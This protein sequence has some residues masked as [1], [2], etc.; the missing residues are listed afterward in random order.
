[1]INYIFNNDFINDI[2][3]SIINFI[4]RANINVNKITFNLSL[5]TGFIISNDNELY[6]NIE[7]PTIIN[8]KI[9]P[10][11][12]KLGGGYFDKIDNDFYIKPEYED[13]FIFG[14]TKLL[15]RGASLRVEYAGTVPVS[16]SGNG[17]IGNE[18]NAFDNAFNSLIT[19]DINNYSSPDFEDPYSFNKG[20]MR[21]ILAIVGYKPAITSYFNHDKGL[22]IALYSLS[23][24]S[25][26]FL[27]IYDRMNL[28][29]YLINTKK[30]KL[31]IKNEL[32]EKTIDDLLELKKEDLL[33]LIINKLYIPYINSVP[34]DKRK[35]VRDEIL[36]GFL[37]A[38][39]A[40]LKINDLN[41]ENYYY[42]SLVNN[43][44]SINNKITEQAWTYFR[45]EVDE[46]YT[47]KLNDIHIE[48]TISNTK[49]GIKEF[50]VEVN[51]GK[52]CINTNKKTI[53]EK[54]LVV[55]MLSYTYLNTIKPDFKERL[56]KG[57]IAL[58]NTNKTF[59]V[60]L[61][62]N[63]LDNRMLTAAVIQLAFKNGYDIKLEDVIN[64]TAY[65]K[66]KEPV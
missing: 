1:M 65:F 63:S 12:I 33:N 45:K 24:D 15:V 20:I 64:D 54:K 53:S 11:T 49:N 59:K 17:F 52:I 41:R 36:K 50:F 34:F 10:A 9:K 61:K 31:A 43:T 39:F 28:I 32:E 3:K 44:V 37:G 25:N 38:N 21:M 46:K 19:E 2:K 13:D 30:S 29:N 16:I 4:S 48:N 58:C 42:A 66:I 18:L 35:K 57:I 5:Y 26:I 14:I 23:V 22:S 56:E 7:H 55:E 62:G 51:N 40:N 27:K 6:I 60:A 8:G 47:N